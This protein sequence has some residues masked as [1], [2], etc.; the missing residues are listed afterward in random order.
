MSD[1]IK[2]GTGKGYTAKVDAQ[3]RLHTGSVARSERDAAI[4][5]GRLFIMSSGIVTLTNAVE[6]PVIYIKN[7]DA[8][9]LYMDIFFATT[10]T[11][12]GGSGNFYTRSHVSLDASSTIITEAKLAAV[13]NANTTSSNAFNGLVYY[14]ETGDTFV[15]TV[16]F[17][18][19]IQQAGSSLETPIRAIL[20]KNGDVAYTYQ[21]PTGNT[22]MEVTVIVTAY[23]LDTELPD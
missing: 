10:G 8:R 11:S 12:T 2:D 17:V 23:Y 6:T 22:S 19:F 14:G 21:A 7:T 5:D 4:A 1:V 13:G 3:G 9:N 15:N 18:T 16:Q 20:Q